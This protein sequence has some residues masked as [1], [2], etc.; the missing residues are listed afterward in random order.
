M[1]VQTN[2]TDD[3]FNEILVQYDLGKST[4]FAPIQSGT[5]QTNYVLTTTQGRFVLRYYE[6]R[7]AES[8]L[9]ESELLE[10]LAQHH[11]P[12]P[13]QCPRN[14]GSFVG[15]WLGKSYILFEFVEGEHVEAL[16]AVHHHQ[17]IQ[18]A[19]QLQTLTKG[20]QSTY[21][22]HRW[23]YTPELVQKL[24]QEK[25]NQL[26]H[27]A[28]YQKYDWIMAQLNNLALPPQLPKGICHCDFHYTNIFFKEDKFIALLDFDDAN[29]TFLQFDLIGLMES[30]AWHHT[31]DQIDLGEARKIVQLYMQFR[32]LEPLEKQ[33]LFDV[34]KLSILID[35]IWFY[36]RWEGERFYERRKIE[37]LDKIG[38]Q[39]FFTALFK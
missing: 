2:F 35:A 15:S 27:E 24:A 22:P 17:L 34:Y 33:H 29:L 28:A 21:A 18:Q 37:S 9:F 25:A 1:T 31:A 39:Q 12:S 19:A 32:P 8:V 11:Y 38:R 7:S 23:N 13:R 6:N 36:N 14:D 3:D 20:Y 26:N 30:A 10:F 16:T 5:V 4:K